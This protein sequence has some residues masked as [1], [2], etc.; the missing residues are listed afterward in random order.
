V[1]SESGRVTVPVLFDPRYRS[2]NLYKKGKL[3]KSNFKEL[4]KGLN[5]DNQ[6]PVSIT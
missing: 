3:F 1:I 6:P 4:A 5:L 2:F